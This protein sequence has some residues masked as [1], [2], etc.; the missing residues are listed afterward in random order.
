MPN[1]TR[2]TRQSISLPRRVAKRVKKIARSTRNSASHVMVQ[3]IE[4]GLEAQEAERKH[5]FEVGERLINST[6]KA[7]QKRLREELARLTFG[8]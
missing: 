2:S 8:E 7:E 3:L 5:F 1:A 6:D 4:K